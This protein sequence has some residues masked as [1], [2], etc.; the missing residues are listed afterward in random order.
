LTVEGGW[1]HELDLRRA[2][3]V[4]EVP[5]GAAVLHPEFPGA[6]DHNKLSLV[7]PAEAQAIAAAADE[8]LGGAGA[9]H[10][11]VE[12]RH[13]GHADGLIPLGYSRSDV[14]VMTWAGGVPAATRPV[15]VLPL[16][17]RVAAAAA[18]WQEEQPDGDP[19]VWRQL[20]ARIATVTS[21]AEAT[22]L[23]IRDADG[24]VVARTDVYVHD[25]VAQVEE[26][27]TDPAHRGR[28]FASALVLEGVRRAH[29]AGADHVFLV[30]DVDD[31]PRRLYEKLGFRDAAVLATYRR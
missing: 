14:L 20:G 10:R 5:G 4:V 19:D 24:R 3:S 11:L 12:L 17:E 22:F 1:L 27:L 16:E 28:G 31:W 6:Y 8:V 18:S 26:V 2:G 7:E 25:G 21:A 13:L 9:A 23:G 15:A 29:G 30:A